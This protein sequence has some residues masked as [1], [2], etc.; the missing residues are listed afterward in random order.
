MDYAY[1]KWTK[2]ELED[3][4]AANHIK[5]KKG[6]KEQ[7][8]REAVERNWE[9]VEGKAGEAY[10]GAKRAAGD[11]YGDAQKAFGDIQREA[12]ETWDEARL[13][14][15]LLEQKVDLSKK[16][17]YGREE[18]LGM[19]RDRWDDVESATG[20]VKAKVADA[21]RKVGDSAQYATEK[22]GEAGSFATKKAEDAQE[23][24]VDSA[25]GVYEGT[26]RAFDASKD[27]V[28]S[29]WDEAQLKAW[30]E[31]KGVIQKKDKTQRTKDQ[32]LGLVHD[33]WGKVANPIWQVWSDSYLVRSPPLPLEFDTDEV[34]AWMARRAQHHQV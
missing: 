21:T 10:G 19:V 15:W 17:S 24:V 18:L 9:K 31:E 34:T 3:W 16:A 1:A 23:A 2:K 6:L 33:S 8:L 5:V 12:Y 29:T 30:L 11:A 7:E 20:Y 22:M 13:R 32:L 26:V 25:K 27:Y 4:L 14:E 28:Y